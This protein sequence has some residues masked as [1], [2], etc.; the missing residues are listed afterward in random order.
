MIRERFRFGIRGSACLAIAAGSL[1]LS[2]CL[3]PRWEAAPSEHFDGRT[4]A[5]ETA[6][7]VGFRDLI[8]YYA[9]REPGAWQRNMAIAPG[10]APPERVDDGSARL[11][12]VNHA[13]VLVQVDGMNVLTDP[14]WSERA[15][16]VSWAGP[17]RYRPP[18]I[19]FEALPPIDV[20][21]V[22]HNHYDHLDIP[23]LHRLMQSHDPVFVVPAGDQVVLQRHGITRAV[24]LD[25]WQTWT[26]PNGCAI[27]ATPVKHWSGR[28]VLPSD[29]NLSLWAGYVIATRDGPIY[30]AGD[31][32]YDSHFRETAA[33]IGPARAALLPIGAYLP[34]WL[35]AYQHMS[36]SEAVTAHVELQA[37]FSLGIH[38]GTFELADDGMHEPAAELARSRHEAGLPV[39]G[40]VAA[41]EGTA[42][43]VPT[44][45]QPTGNTAPCQPDTSS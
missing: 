17:R 34:R 45:R 40:I 21:V 24:P 11:T 28:R 41:T 22:S 33:R 31:T 16:P 30:F 10:A 3:S 38:H 35:T 7:D 32:G 6:F 14:I 18:G 2:G 43:L 27:T 44:R 26:M 8:R 15:S 20:V 23:T 12:F 4:F 9:T 36:P 1:L 13:T 5:N 29:R 42:Y 19:A 25:W 37:A 39:G